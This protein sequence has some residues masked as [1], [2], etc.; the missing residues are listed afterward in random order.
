MVGSQ[1]HPEMAQVF[2]L[3]KREAFVFCFRERGTEKRREVRGKNGEERE[4]PVRWV[5]VR[6]ISEQ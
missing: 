1:A 6:L 2:C 3:R 5:K 4:K